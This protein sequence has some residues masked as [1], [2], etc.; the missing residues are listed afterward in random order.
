MVISEIEHPSNSHRKL[1]VEGVYLL[2]LNIDIR[3]LA[4][5]ATSYEQG[6]QWAQTLAEN[7]WKPLKVMIAAGLKV[8][9]NYILVLEAFQEGEGTVEVC[10]PLCANR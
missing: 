2:C 5:S 4:P 7:L 10:V 8:C 9:L 1:N 3:L 6:G